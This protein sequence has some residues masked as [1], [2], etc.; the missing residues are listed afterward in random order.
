MNEAEIRKGWLA[1]NAIVAFVGSLF[2]AQAW[3]M[4]QAW[5]AFEGTV[6]PFVI[7]TVPT[8]PNYY[9]FVVFLFIAVPFVLS[10]FL[11]LATIVTRL[12][13]WAIPIAAGF[14]LTL[15][16]I[17]LAA[18][19]VSLLS[20]IPEL[21]LDQWWSSC[22]I[23]GGIALFFFLLYRLFDMVKSIG[24]ETNAGSTLIYDRRNIGGWS[25]PTLAF[26]AS[27][28]TLEVRA[29]GEIVN[30]TGQNE[31]LGRWRREVMNAVQTARHGKAWSSNDEHAISIGLRFHPDSHEG[32]N[33]DIDN[34]TRATINAIAAG[35]FSDAASETVDHWDF[36][37][38]NFRTLLIHRLPDADDASEEGAA[39]FVSSWRKKPSLKERCQ[40]LLGAVINYANSISSPIRQALLRLFRTL[41]NRVRSAR[42]RK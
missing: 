30:E 15:M 29:E 8:V 25:V 18:F 7:F 32:S 12:Q 16:V 21:P 34:Y 31:K 36:P 20:A 10:L 24:T 9:G 42:K 19:L 23:W 40:A 14:S 22:L 17:F 37:D 11:A 27:G 28:R 3:G 4:A 1:G 33:F 2:V 35:L 13:R 5:G 39:I 6:E 26:L 41:L 38:S